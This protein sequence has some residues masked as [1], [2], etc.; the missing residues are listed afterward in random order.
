MD[1]KTLLFIFYLT[2]SH[3]IFSF[4]NNQVLDQDMNIS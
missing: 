2:F 3:N 1:N 4:F